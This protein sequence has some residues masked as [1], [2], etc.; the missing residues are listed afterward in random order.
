MT[1]RRQI[2]QLGRLINYACAC[3]PAPNIK[4][5]FRLKLNSYEEADMVFETPG[6]VNSL[7]L[8]EHR[9]LG[10]SPDRVHA[11]RLGDVG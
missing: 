9:G 1:L 5:Q 10:G 4:T 2:G 11:L 8:L 3:A 6:E 7:R